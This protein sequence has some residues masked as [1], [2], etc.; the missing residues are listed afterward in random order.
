MRRLVD[1]KQLSA[2]SGRPVRQLRT[3]VQQGKIPCFRVGYRSLLFDVLKV[4]QALARFE[5]PAVGMK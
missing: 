2:E 4:E 5:V 3:L 1:I